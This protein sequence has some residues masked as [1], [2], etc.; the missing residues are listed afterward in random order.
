MP[1]IV[2]WVEQIAKPTNTTVQSGLAIALT[3]FHQEL[4]H[5]SGGPQFARD[6]GGKAQIP[7]G[8]EPAGLNIGRQ[9]TY[10]FGKS[11]ED[12]RDLVCFE[13]SFPGHARPL[14]GL[15]AGESS[16][17]IPKYRA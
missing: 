13:P 14:S 6:V 8:V 1:L 4:A 16:T 17:A 5:P 11:C 15:V 3:Q 7:L 9:L 12:L 2:G 10:G